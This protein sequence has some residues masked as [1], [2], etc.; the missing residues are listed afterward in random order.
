MIFTQISEAE[1]EAFQKHHPYRNFLNSAA[2]I[3]LKKRSNWEV[4]FV[5]VKEKDELLCACF[6]SAIP[7]MKLYKYYYA[8]R[9][10]L[11]DFRDRALLHFFIE[12]MVAYLKTKKALYFHIDPF[13]FAQQR[14]INGDVVEGGFDNR[15]IVEILKEEQ[16]I[17]QGYTIGNSS[18]FQCRWMF[19]LPLVG[20]S[21]E[22]ILANMHQQTRWSI[23]KTLRD[24]IEVRELKEDELSIFAEMM[25][26]TSKRRSFNDRGIEYYRNF[27][28]VYGKECKLLLAY[29][30][31]EK[32]LEKLQ[33]ELATTLEELTSVEEHLKENE[34]SKKFIKRK[35][36]LI[37]AVELYH[38]KIA[39]SL[40]LEKQ[41][42]KVIPMAGSMFVLQ[43]DEVTYLHSG[44][45][46]EFKR[47]NAPY[48]L[49]WHMI[50]YAIKHG[51]GRYN[52]YG[53]SG[54][55]RKEAEDYGVYDFKKGF[56]GVVE[57][58]IGDFYLPINK[59]AFAL[60]KKLKM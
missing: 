7:I 2:A 57:E 25:D 43:G 42:G 34:I 14:D 49:Q 39:D 20:E 56:N 22:S 35:K 21:E 26:V 28:E 55:F 13:V 24:G 29:L 48:A 36:V 18:I 1:F 44:T 54:D 59:K 17:H 6:L 50:C 9:G 32:H 38:K 53:I 31:V 40:V 3:R 10:L 8:S 45:F 12:N 41:H 5:G 33:G 16:F 58:L 19:T 37:E 60:Y 47:F 27:I 23:N 46:D 51:Y 52:F 4:E 11:I 15:D 30:D